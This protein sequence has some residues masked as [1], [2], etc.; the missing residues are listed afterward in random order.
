MPSR[1]RHERVSPSRPVKPP[2]DQLWALAWS[3][4]KGTRTLTTLDGLAKAY[5]E[6]DCRVWIDLESPGPDVLQPLTKLLGMHPLIAEDILERNQRAKIEKTGDAIHLVMFALEYRGEIVPHE[7]DM[8][9]GERFLLTAHDEDFNLRDA[10]FHRREPDMHLDKGADFAL[11]LVTDWLVDDYFPVFDKLGD[12]I[13]ELEVDVVRRPGP[14]IVERLFTLRRDLLEIRHAVNPQRE[15]FNQLTNRDDRLIPAERIVYFR[16]V[17]DHLIRLTDELDSYRELVST[18]LD[19][20]L[21]QINNNL[22]E[23]MKRLTGVT[24]VLATIGAIGGIFGMSEAGA[25]F[26]LT[27]S[28]G[29]WVITIVSVL[30]ALVFYLVLRRRG[31]I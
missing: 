24:V 13:D 20:Y 19:V 6:P 28:S 29:F 3:E 4:A 15:I 31:Y 18:T 2:P 21:S 16:D 11:W 17:Y 22:S 26:N 27:E 14:L 25:A 12:E 8:V 5:K 1:R 23:I 10:P 7:L 30:I 9:L